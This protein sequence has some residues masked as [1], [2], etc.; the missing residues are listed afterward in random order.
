MV[1]PLKSAALT[2]AGTSAVSTAR[3]AAN[4]LMIILLAWELACLYVA[5]FEANVQHCL[6]LLLFH[7]L[8]GSVERGHEL[9]RLGDPLAI[10]AAC[11]HHLLEARR[12]LERGEGRLLLARGITLWIRGEGGTM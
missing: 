6:P 7:R 4:T 12:R 10:P 2:A 8:Q 11:L 3:T 9:R 1:L 5:Y